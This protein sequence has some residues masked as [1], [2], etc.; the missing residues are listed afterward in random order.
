MRNIFIIIIAILLLPIPTSVAKEVRADSTITERF[1]IYY[2]FDKTDIQESY[3][4]NPRQFERI[5]RY[6]NESPRIDS[7]TIYS[8]ASPE[9]AYRHNVWLSRE[10]GKSAKRFLLAHSPDS[11]KLNSDKIKISPLAENWPGLAELVERQYFR[12]DREKVLRILRDSSIGDETR[13]WRLQQLDD[14]YTW[15][16]LLRKYMPQLRTATWICVWAEVVEDLPELEEPVNMLSAPISVLQKPKPVPQLPSRKT[17]L[18]LKTNLLYDAVTAVNAEL[19]LP[20]GEQFSVMVE[21]VFPWWSWGPNGN[22]YA[23][24]LW[25][26]G[27]EPRWW[28]KRTEGRD[29]LSGHFLGVYALSGRYDFQNNTDI[30]YQGEAWSTGLSYGYAMPLGRTKLNLEFSAS[31]GFMQSNYRHYQPDPDY[32]KLY[33]DPHL[34]GKMSYFGPTK[35]K[36]SLVL[37]ITVNI[38]KGGMR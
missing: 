35:L 27:I 26:M 34:K 12:H 2:R 6:L 22:K 7:I 11:T 33:R 4:D 18:A 19:E 8:W 23:F 31:L 16:F 36:V 29:R 21:D 13:K 30:C 37:P 17:I 20:I 1:A 3:L 25:E 24:Q 38:R 32:G 14:G 28:F 15:N 9:G 10:R 5:I